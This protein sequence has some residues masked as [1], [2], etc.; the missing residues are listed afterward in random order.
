MLFAADHP[1][2]IIIGVEK[3]SDT[4]G[5]IFLTRAEYPWSDGCLRSLRKSAKSLLIITTIA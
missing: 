2:G 1:F 4:R 5:A 3:H